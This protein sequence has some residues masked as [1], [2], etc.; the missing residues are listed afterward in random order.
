MLK[1]EWETA[2]LL[3]LQDLTGSL[4]DL[5]AVQSVRFTLPCPL[6]LWL[7]LILGLSFLILSKP[8]FQTLS[9]YS[10]GPN[11]ISLGI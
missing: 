6:T 10:E 1:T 11:K 8:G 7:E 9:I 5:T 2:S 4:P 3:F